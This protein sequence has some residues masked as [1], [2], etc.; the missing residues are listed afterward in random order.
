[1]VALQYYTSLI[2][3]SHK[4]GMVDNIEGQTTLINSTR[5]SRIKRHTISTS[6]PSNP[7]CRD[8]GMFTKGE[9]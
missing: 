4:W 1:M 9:E 5:S 7:L 6:S 2:S 3:I 8:L